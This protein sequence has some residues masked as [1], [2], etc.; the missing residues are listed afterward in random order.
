[1]TKDL[2]KGKIAQEID[3]EVPEEAEIDPN[4][5]VNRLFK[6]RR[7]NGHSNG[8]SVRNWQED[9]RMRFTF[10]SVDIRWITK[11]EQI[12]MTREVHS[13]GTDLHEMESHDIRGSSRSLD[14]C[15]QFY[16]EK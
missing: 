1:L 5:I 8:Q 3:E 10:R 2:P 6:F 9:R 13:E 15:D 11:A 12:P 4:N 14:R 7:F 16:S